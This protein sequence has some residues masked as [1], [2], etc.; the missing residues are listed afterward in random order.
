MRYLTH[1][2]IQEGALAVLTAFADFCEQEGI[3]HVLSFGTLLGAARHR[4]FI[5][6]DDD[7]DVGVPRPDYDRLHGLADEL[8]AATGFRLASLRGVPLEASPF[9]KVVDPNIRITEVGVETPGNLWIDVFPIDGLPEDR[10]EAARLC[11]RLKRRISFFGAMTSTPRTA[12]GVL[13]K[14]V[15]W[16]LHTLGRLTSPEAVGASICALA[17]SCDFTTSERVTALSWSPYPIEGSFKRTSLEE[18]E[19][20]PFEGRAFPVVAEWRTVLERVY[21]DYMTP[22]PVGKRETHSVKAWRE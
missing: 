13:R 14:T 6:W 5:P 22:P 16:G 9:L 7:I 1:A 18:P 12:N 15:R 3:R 4:G 20:L 11:R 8:E 2:E 21:G 17:K 10:R 19:S